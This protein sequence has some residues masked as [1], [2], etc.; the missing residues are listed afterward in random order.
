ME[1]VGGPAPLYLAAQIPLRE[2]LVDPSLS[3]ACVLLV[4]VSVGWIFV[5]RRILKDMRRVGT[6][7]PTRTDVVRPP[8]DIWSYP[9]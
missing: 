7:R 9:P 3:V 5:W 4:V 6:R 1:G 2:F 8:R